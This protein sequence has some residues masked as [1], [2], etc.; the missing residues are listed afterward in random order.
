[1]MLETGVPVAIMGLDHC[2]GS[3]PKQFVTLRPTHSY[4]VVMETTLVI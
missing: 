3:T 1:L 2:Q 4:F